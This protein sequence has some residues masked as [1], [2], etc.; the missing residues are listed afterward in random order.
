M[1]AADARRPQ[2][3]HLGLEGKQSLLIMG[4]SGCGK[5]S[6]LRAICGLWVQGSGTITVPGDQDLFFL[7]QKPFMP[8]GTLRDQLLFPSGAAL[9]MRLRLPSC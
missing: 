6:L 7:P 9:A 4:Q 1:P 3:L 2:N 8:L 5:S